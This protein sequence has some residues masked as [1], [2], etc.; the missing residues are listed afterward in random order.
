MLPFVEKTDGQRYCIEEAVQWVIS[1][2]LSMAGSKLQWVFNILYRSHED[3][4]VRVDRGRTF[5]ADDN[6]SQKDS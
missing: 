6:Q 2:F 1:L 4:C 3:T 5:P